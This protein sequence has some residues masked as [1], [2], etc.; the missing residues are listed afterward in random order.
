MTMNTV[1][2]AQTRRP[3]PRN[4]GQSGDPVAMAVTANTAATTGNPRIKRN[5]KTALPAA[6]RRHLLPWRRD[7]IGHE[8][9]RPQRPD[10]D[11]G[12]Q[13]HLPY[14]HQ[15]PEATASAMLLTAQATNAMFITTPHGRWRVRSAFAERRSISGLRR[16]ATE[17]ARPP[18]LRRQAKASGTA[19][20]L[21]GSR[22]GGADGALHVS[23][24]H[25]PKPR[26]ATLYLFP[27]WQFQGRKPASIGVSDLRRKNRSVRV[28]PPCFLMCNRETHGEASN[29]GSRKPQSIHVSARMGD[30]DHALGFVGRRFSSTALR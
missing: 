7:G 13:C 27:L 1:R 10:A 5:P 3:I 25:C 6:G 23:R 30:A 12:E 16:C 2:H 22:S 26:G 11:E 8:Q 15:R 19:S 20:S 14:R 18:V 24:Y 17:R 29:V 28:L 21:H 9:R 4:Q